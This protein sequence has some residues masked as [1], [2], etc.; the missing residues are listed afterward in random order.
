MGA[1]VPLASPGDGTKSV[2]YKDLSNPGYVRE[3]ERL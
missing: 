1:I 2:M 3:V